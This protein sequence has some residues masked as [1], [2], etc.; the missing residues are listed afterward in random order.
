MQPRAGLQGGEAVKQLAKRTPSEANWS[1]LG[2][3]TSGLP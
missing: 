2:L 3:E 1:R